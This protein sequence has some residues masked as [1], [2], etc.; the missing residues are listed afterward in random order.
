MAQKSSPSVEYQLVE[1]IQPQADGKPALTGVA[2]GP[3]RKVV[4]ELEKTI[5]GN[6][7]NYVGAWSGTSV[8]TA[9]AGNLANA[10]NPS[11]TTSPTVA[12]ASLT[13]GKTTFT[14]TRSASTNSNVVCFASH[15]SIK[16]YRAK[17]YHST[18]G[19]PVFDGL[20]CYK[21]ADGSIG[22]YDTVSDTF[23]QA[24]GTWSKGADVT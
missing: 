5:A 20:P 23:Y 14:G 2:A 10:S 12:Q 17:V 24:V 6:N 16:L 1:W 18:N 13:N 3:T 21:T 22:L 8:T 9:A 11:Y 15:K 4:V 7:G 19:D